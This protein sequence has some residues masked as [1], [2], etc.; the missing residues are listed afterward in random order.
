MHLTGE[1]DHMYLDACQ[2]VLQQVFTK[3]RL[4]PG[5]GISRFVEVQAP[6]RKLTYYRRS[7]FGRL[8]KPSL[9]KH[10]LHKISQRILAYH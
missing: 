9:P 2:S 5:K 10:W 4:P 7:S 1:C 3:V 8:N 6:L